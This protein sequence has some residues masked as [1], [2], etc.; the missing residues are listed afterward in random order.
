MVMENGSEEIGVPGPKTP[1]GAEGGP[2]GSSGPPD[3][4]VARM[5]MIDAAIRTSS[6]S[7]N[8]LT[9]FD[10]DAIMVT[11]RRYAMFFTVLS[12]E[13]AV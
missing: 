5:A 9:R 10:M 4:R 8:V 7:R 2:G 11:P 6:T 1:D 3:A 13:G 12:F